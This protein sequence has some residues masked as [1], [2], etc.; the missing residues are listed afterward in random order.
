MKLRYPQVLLF[1]CSFCVWPTTFAAESAAKLDTPVGGWRTG[2][3]EGDGENFR[4]IVNYPA[5]SVNTPVGQ[6]NTARITGQI[7]A[8]PKSGSRAG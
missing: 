3:P 5:S 4:Q 6:A 8:T 7:N 2:A 1:L